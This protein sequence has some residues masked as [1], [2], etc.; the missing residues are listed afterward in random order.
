MYNHEEVKEEVKVV[1]KTSEVQTKEYEKAAK[2]LANAN[3]VSLA[4][5]LY[6]HYSAFLFLL[7][8]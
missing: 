6:S 1:H 2:R 3:L 4:N 8:I 7:N 5:P